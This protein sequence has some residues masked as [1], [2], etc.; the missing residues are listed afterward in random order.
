[1][2]ATENDIP[3]SKGINIY[4]DS[5]RIRFHLCML[6][7]ICFLTFGNYFCYDMVGAFSPETLNPFY[8]VSTLKTNFLYSI[9]SLPNIILP[10]FSGYVVDRI[11]GVK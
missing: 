5:R 3:S 10:F 4:F 6:I 11:L 7:G 9:Y 1:M 8:D 2:F